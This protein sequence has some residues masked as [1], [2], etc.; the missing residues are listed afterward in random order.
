[1]F[2]TNLLI[3]QCKLNDIALP[4]GLFLK[5]RNDFQWG[6][7]PRRAGSRSQYCETGSIQAGSPKLNCYV[8]L[9]KGD[10]YDIWKY[11]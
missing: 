3:A 8:I 11:S 1:M 9:T 5:K 7:G 10:N 2:R 4:G 6:G